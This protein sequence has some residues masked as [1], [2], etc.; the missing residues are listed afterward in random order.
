MQRKDRNSDT[1]A[2]NSQIMA[3]LKHLKAQLALKDKRIKE[4]EGEVK[5]LKVDVLNRLTNMAVVSDTDRMLK[6]E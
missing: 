1:P 4:L 5:T 3:E 6:P 2:G